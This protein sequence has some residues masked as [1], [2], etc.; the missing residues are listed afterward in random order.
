MVKRELLAKTYRG[1]RV[2][3]T[4]HTGFKGSWL[5]VLLHSLGAQVK[6]YSLEPNSK[7]DLYPTIS[8]D[9]F[10]ESV[11]ADIRDR[12]RLEKE[13]LDFQPDF[14]I[15]MAAQALVI[16]SYLYPIETYQ[17]NVMGTLHVIEALRKLKKP[18][19]STMITT[20]KVYW[21]YE[22]EEPYKEDERLAG[23]DPYS[24]SKA[25]ADLSI[26]SHVLSFL[27][28]DKYEEHQQ[29]ICT[30]RSG[31]VIGGGDF[32][33]NRIIPDCVKALRGEQPIILRNPQAVRPWQHVLDPLYG[34]LLLGAKLADEP[35]K[36]NQAYNFGPSENDVKT[37][38]ELVQ[39]AI[40]SWGSGKYQY[41]ENLAKPHEAGLLKL[42]IEKAKVE[43]NWT[44]QLD[45]TTA[46]QQTIEWYKKAQED[47]LDITMRQ[48]DQFLATPS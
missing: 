23:F 29:A 37:V 21:N 19:F 43:L 26:Q 16:D 40:D 42:S 13:I 5:T 24:N 44:P 34:Y 33:E 4:G 25:C 27:H 12:E 9:E 3:L 14:V 41:A 31:N 28:P 10:C 18:C 6:G 38:E 2:F 39:I 36:F 17:T 11:I 30:V 22:R 15:H 7:E 32:S 45:A 1:K 35:L 20:D 46:I 48:I 47:A 8:G